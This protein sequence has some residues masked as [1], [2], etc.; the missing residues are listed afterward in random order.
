MNKKIVL[1][2]RDAAPSGCFN[3]LKPVLEA[4]GFEVV[5]FAGEG[6]PLTATEDEIIN[7]VSSANLV[8]L[9]MSAKDFA[10]PEIVAGEVARK[11]GVPYGFYGDVPKCFARAR[12]GAWFES[13]AS[14]AGFYFGID[15]EDAQGARRVFPKAKLF[16]T[17]NP[18]R[19]E[20]AFPR[21]TREKVREKLGILPGEKLVLVPGLKLISENMATL[22]TVS[23]ALSVLTV[24]GH[25]FRLVFATHPGDRNPYAIDSVTQKEL[26]LYEG[27]FSY[28]PIN[29]SMV[30]KDFLSTS[31]M[32]PGADIIIEFGSSIGI[33]GAY[34]NIPVITLAFGI[35]FKRYEETAG[36]TELESVSR[37]LSE[38]VVAETNLLAGMIERL[39]TPRGFKK[40]RA[41]QQE[42]YPK[43]EERGV[44]LKKMAAAVREIL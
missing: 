5:V 44:A 15:D 11:A 24:E 38:L 19:E 40:M 13:L 37:G 8:I 18:L 1:V 7:T 31:D 22:V 6:K 32:V 23:E 21:L 41:R 25:Q 9:G 12:P 29:S 35:M 20:M 30:A 39:L 27:F 14:D 3:R 10:E 28:S 43:P 36:T 2:A 4:Q 42:L 33:E 34:Q 16:A 26:K 17:G